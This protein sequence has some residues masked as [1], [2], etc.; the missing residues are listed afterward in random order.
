MIKEQ[1]YISPELEMLNV[2]TEQC[3]LTVSSNI[4]NIGAPKEELPWDATSIILL[5]VE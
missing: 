5:T 4:E 1:K 2:E 3:I